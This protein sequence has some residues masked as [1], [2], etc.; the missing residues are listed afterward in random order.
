[1][2]IEIAARLRPFSHM[3][4][5][6]CLIPHTAVWLRA[7]PMRLV[8]DDSI[9]VEWD[10]HGPTKDFTLLQDLERGCVQVFG[11]WQE[12]FFLWEIEGKEGMLWL[13][14]QRGPKGGCAIN[15]RTIFCK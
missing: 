1:M 2:N 5:T 12:G 6:A 11:T 8:I 15:G 3:S 13:R 4:G 10:L 9:V 7:F 14:L